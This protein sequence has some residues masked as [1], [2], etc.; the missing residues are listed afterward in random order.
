MSYTAKRLIKSTAVSMAVGFAC[1]CAL[2][3]LCGCATKTRNVEIEGMFTQAESATL[4][5][6]KVDV[7]A[8]PQG[9]ESAIIKYDEDTALLSPSTKTHEIKIQLTGTNCVDKVDAIIEHICRA[10][11][12][13]AAI[14]KDIVPPKEG[15]A[16]K[17]AD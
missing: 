15:Q 2:I 7:M 14:M 8:T 5:I 17:V 9:E 12:P 3:L 16:R 6:G 10:F 13:T 1:A 11:V 4:A